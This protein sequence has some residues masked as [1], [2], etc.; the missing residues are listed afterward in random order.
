MAPPTL[1]TSL[2][3][4]TAPEWL[5]FCLQQAAHVKGQPQAYPIP[6]RV[7]ARNGESELELENLSPAVLRQVRVV[8]L[9]EGPSELSLPTRVLPGQR[10]RVSLAQPSADS[11]MLV[12]WLHRNGVE[13]VWPITW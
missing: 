4:P 6:W 1:V 9:S 5:R 13:L 7:T 12:R 8:L 2:S 11:M 3:R 10:I